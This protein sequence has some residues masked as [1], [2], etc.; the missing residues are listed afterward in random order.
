[1][2]F[3]RVTQLDIGLNNN[4]GVRISN[5]NFTFELERSVEAENNYMKLTIYNAKR[6]TNQGL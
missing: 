1:M 6:E 5:L 3:Q 2:A 4:T